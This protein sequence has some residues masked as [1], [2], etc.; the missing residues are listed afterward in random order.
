M[1]AFKCSE[2][3]RES[4]ESIESIDMQD[5]FM[6][7][8]SNYWNG[9]PNEFPGPGSGSTHA[10]RSSTM[11]RTRIPKRAMVVNQTFV[12]EG[13]T[14]TRQQRFYNLSGNLMLK[15]DGFHV[16][17]STNN[18]MG[19]AFWSPMRHQARI[20]KYRIQ[21]AKTGGQ[22]AVARTLTLLG[23]QDK[24]TF[25]TLD[26]AVNPG[27]LDKF[28]RRVS[29]TNGF[30]Y[31]CLVIGSVWVQPRH[32]NPQPPLQASIQTSEISLY[33]V[34]LTVALCNIQWM[35]LGR[36]IPCPTHLP[37]PEKQRQFR[38]LS[39]IYIQ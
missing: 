13:R 25:V 29:I 24:K 30:S 37:L 36:P 27:T 26:V 5:A 21:P 35:Y 31:Y 15:G 17:N 20:L 3:S 33:S 34:A 39:S 18:V 10:I 9:N 1:R 4:I 2:H 23:T 12:V 32:D 19:E 11:L 28:E 14:E 38:V 6:F 22:A 16:S 8:Y 7:A